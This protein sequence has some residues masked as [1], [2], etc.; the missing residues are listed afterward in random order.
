MDLKE[1]LG[2]ELYN[3]VSEKVG[4]K[5]KIAVVSDGNWFPK[6]KF[7]AVNTDNKELKQQLK[8][9]DTQLDDLKTKAAGHEDLTKQIED[10]KAQNQKSTQEYQDKLNKQAFDF[11]LDKSLT[12]AK[13][14][15][16]KAVRALLDTET[17]KLDGEKLSGL[18]D[19]LKALKESDSYLFDS[20][21]GGGGDAKPTPTFSQGQHQK[22]NN[23]DPFVSA[24]G[25]KGGNE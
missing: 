19:Q 18:D 21:E 15:N 16:P 9:R 12:G 20:D 23:A 3:Q 24:L 13:A 17:I 8:D 22:Q 7:D 14:K 10:L 2:E 11:A 5:H 25:L 6:E 1:L 4:D